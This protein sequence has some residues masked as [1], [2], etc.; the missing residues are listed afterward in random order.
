HVRLALGADGVVR[1]ERVRSEIAEPHARLPWAGHGR[2]AE[3]PRVLDRPVDTKA[4]VDLA[5]IACAAARIDGVDAEPLDRPPERGDLVAAP[6]RRLRRLDRV[7]VAD[8]DEL[9]VEIEPPI[10]GRQR[11]VAD[12]EACARL[13]A[14]AFDEPGHALVAVHDAARLVP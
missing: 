8:E 1:Q 5:R 12:L 14:R 13:V 9:A 11:Q 6:L 3:L 4:A 7:R 2:D 10:R